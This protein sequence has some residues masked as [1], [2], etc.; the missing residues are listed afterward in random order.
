MK[1]NSLS[2]FF[3]F[4][5]FFSPEEG[6]YCLYWS[7]PKRALKAAHSSMT[8]KYAELGDTESKS[9]VYNTVKENDYYIY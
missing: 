2:I 8:T 5:F 6:K 7:N 9:Q 3:H 1:Y 4:D